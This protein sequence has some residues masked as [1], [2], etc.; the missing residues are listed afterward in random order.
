MSSMAAAW[1]PW[2]TK[3]PSADSRSWAR[4][5]L[6]GIRALRGFW[7]SVVVTAMPLHLADLRSSLLLGSPPLAGPDSGTHRDAGGPEGNMDREHHPASACCT[8]EATD[9]DE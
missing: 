2:A 6:R 7:S 9:K 8:G 1:Y 3:A 5:S 4:R